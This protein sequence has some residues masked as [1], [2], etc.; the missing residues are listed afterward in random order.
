MRIGCAL[1]LL[2]CYPSPAQAEDEA[3][4]RG[5]RG[6]AVAVI[7]ASNREWQGRLLEVAKDAVTVEIDGEARRIAFAEIR[8]VDAHGDR[9]IDGGVRGA[10]VGAAIAML[11]RTPRFAGHAA[12]TY[13]L[14]G[15]GLDAL[16]DCTHTVY[17]A[18]PVPARGDPGR[19]PA[20]GLTV[21]W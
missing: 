18:A 19:K 8:R 4:L 11:V 9:V 1:L 14:I 13:G 21:S 6:R 10:L 20:L 17:R 15:L 5:S 2:L 7:D 3:K 16:N 12:V